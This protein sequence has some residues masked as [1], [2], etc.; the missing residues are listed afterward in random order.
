MTIDCIDV[1]EEVLDRL[2]G[3]CPHY[4]QCQ[5]DEEEANHEQMIRCLGGAIEISSVTY[6]NEFTP[7]KD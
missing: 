7:C 4:K 1:C 5:N 2:C 6:P 3:S